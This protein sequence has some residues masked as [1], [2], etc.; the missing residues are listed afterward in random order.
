M[1]RIKTIEIQAKGFFDLLKEREIS[2][3]S[4]FQEMINANEE[5]LIQFLNEDKTIIAEYI[6][7]TT[8]ER[9]EEDRKIFAEI[10]KEKLGHK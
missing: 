6:L 3:W 9:L 2:M 8:K 4:I 7:P 5:Q 10:F 1:S